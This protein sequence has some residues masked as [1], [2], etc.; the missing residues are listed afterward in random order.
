MGRSERMQHSLYNG[1]RARDRQ[2]KHFRSRD[3]F[4]L[5]ELVVLG[6]DEVGDTTCR[7]V[8]FEVCTKGKLSKL[9][10]LNESKG[11]LDWSG[12]CKVRWS[13]IGAITG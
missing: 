9:G 10:T 12:M 3:C 1:S 7:R 4:G 8:S 6:N 13:S 5:A 2:I 11:G